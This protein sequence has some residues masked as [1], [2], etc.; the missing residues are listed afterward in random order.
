VCGNSVGKYAMVGAGAVVTHDVPDFALVFGTPSKIK[1]W[2]CKCGV[3]LVHKTI[4]G[5]PI[6]E[7]PNEVAL[8]CPNCGSIYSYQKE[9]DLFKPLEEKV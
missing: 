9:K 4:K 8:K 2:V 6:K 7:T 5:I 3:V 1:G